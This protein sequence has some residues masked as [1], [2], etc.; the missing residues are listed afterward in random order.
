MPQARHGDGGFATDPPCLTMR[1]Q[2]ITRISLRDDVPLRW[3][4]CEDYS[5]RWPMPSKQRVAGSN[6]AGRASLTRRNVYPKRVQEDFPSLR[7]F[8]V[9]E[10]LGLLSDL[11]SAALAFLPISLA[12]AGEDE[13]RR[14]AE[15]V[16]M[17]A[18]VRHDEVWE[19]DDAPASARFGAA[20]RVTA[21]GRI[22]DL[23]GNADGAGVQVDVLQGER[24]E[25]GPAEASEGGEQD[26]HAVAGAD[27]VGEGVDPMPGH[28]S[29]A[30]PSRS[31]RVRRSPCGRSQPPG[32]NA[33]HCPGRPLQRH[34]HPTL[35]RRSLCRPSEPDGE[36]PAARPGPP[37]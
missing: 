26:Q 18:E 19:G 22:V 17:L 27:G 5:A 9:P 31:R 12:R 25:F 16:E 15:S 3:P 14:L 8:R 2:I 21:A 36:G 1:E 7:A 6:P 4:S 28:T 29:R 30:R 11:P 24:G 33:A 13:S 37:A 34:G 20:E 32:R 23:A 10:R 35:E